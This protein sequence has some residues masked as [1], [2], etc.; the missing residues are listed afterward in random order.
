M[1]FGGKEFNQLLTLSLADNGKTLRQKISSKTSYQE[2]QNV[3]I[4]I[5]T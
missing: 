3:G 1:E 5:L 2:I 4:Q